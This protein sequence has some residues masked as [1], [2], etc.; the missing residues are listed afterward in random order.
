[1]SFN[2][3]MYLDYPITTMS[4]RAR[5]VFSPASGWVATAI[6]HHRPF[7]ERRPLAYM[8]INAGYMVL[9]FIIM[10]LIIGAWR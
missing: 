9:S 7:R 8:L 2:L 5:R 1:M 10:G 6:S 3:A 4:W